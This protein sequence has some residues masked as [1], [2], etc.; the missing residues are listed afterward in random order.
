M[1][2]V[3]PNAHWSRNVLSYCKEMHLV[4]FGRMTDVFDMFRDYFSS[5]TLIVYLIIIDG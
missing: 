2:D 1:H 4:P 3:I 5:P